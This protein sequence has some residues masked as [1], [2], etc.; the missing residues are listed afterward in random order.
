MSKKPRFEAGP[1]SSLLDRS[2]GFFSP[3]AERRRLVARIHVNEL[4]N[5][6]AAKRGRRTQNWRT[7]TNSVNDLLR[8]GL[9]LLRARSRDLTRNNPWGNRALNVVTNNTVGI[10]IRPQARGKNAQTLVSS[11]E[12]RWN[13]W[14]ESTLCDADG[15]QSFYGLQGLV[16]RTVAESGSCLVR[17]R[18]RR[19][20]DGMAVPLQ[21]QVLEPDYLDATKDTHVGRLANGHRIIHGI[22]FDRRGKRVAYHLFTEFPGSSVYSLESVRV[23]AEDVI[24]VF[25]VERAGQAD[26]VP[27]GAPVIIK[28]RDLD[29]YEDAELMRQKIAACFVAFVTKDDDD[30]DTNADEAE[31]AARFEPGMIEQLGAGESVTF[32][33]PS[34][35]GESTV[36]K[37]ALLAI[38]ATYGITYESLTNDYSNVNF[39]SGRMGWIDMRHNVNAWRHGMLNPQFNSR[40]WSWFL[41]GGA[42]SGALPQGLPANWVPPRREMIDPTKETE[43]NKQRV[44]AGF[45]SWSAAIREEGGDP[46]E[47]LD[48]IKADYDKVLAK[49]LPLEAFVLS[50][51]PVK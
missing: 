51:V 12:D 22:E 30:Q 50:P 32:G 29:E 40:V 49:G 8:G 5:Y 46:D 24:H 10:G 27:W 23:P 15:L 11:I 31:R 38:A 36:A 47:L 14:G 45:V 7:G 20:S 9:P 28:V 25:R 6:E 21:L 43:A 48:E 16:L 39:S 2:I 41:E 17:R 18:W 19:A 34:Q 37:R 1:V 26:G 4:R 33:Q 42:L 44:R 13:E 35:P 3:A